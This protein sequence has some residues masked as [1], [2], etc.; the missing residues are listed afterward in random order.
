[1]DGI[2]QKHHN[3]IDCVQV[4]HCK[5]KATQDYLSIALSHQITYEFLMLYNYI[6]WSHSIRLHMHRP[7]AHTHVHTPA[8]PLLHTHT[9]YINARNWTYTSLLQGYVS[10]VPGGGGH[11]VPWK[12]WA[13]YQ[14][15][16]HAIRYI[17]VCMKG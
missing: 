9:H 14:D 17:T 2:L 11:Y 7:H 8:P 13:F 12:T 10:N 1:M 16:E 5:L 6:K 4:C 15:M 3:I